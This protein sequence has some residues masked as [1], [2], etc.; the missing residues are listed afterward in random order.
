MHL[1][2]EKKNPIGLKKNPSDEKP[3]REKMINNFFI[4]FLLERK[5]RAI[6]KYE[7]SQ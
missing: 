1:E 7:K 5:R 2:R 6:K 3:R 4:F